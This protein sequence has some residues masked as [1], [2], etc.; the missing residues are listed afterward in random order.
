MEVA[1]P[2]CALVFDFDGTLSVGLYLERL[3]Q[4]AVA[5]KVP[6]FASMS[7]AE[8][9]LNFGG[10]ARLGALRAL[11]GELRASN[12]ALFVCSIGYKKAIVPHLERMDLL[13]FFG[14]ARV[15]GQ[16][17]EEL[18][19]RQFAKADFVRDLVALPLG[20]EPTRVL[21]ID[22]SPKHI[23]YARATGACDTLHVAGGHG[24]SDDDLDAIRQ[25]RSS[26]VGQHLE[27]AV[28]E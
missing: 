16:D 27:G 9:C 23:D 12:S 8:M 13:R 11:L 6:L 15:F 21:F 28:G 2:D 24:L 22:D 1:H 25:W 10:T 17:C 26:V 18:Q 4:W 7:E 20:L 5:D 14:E 19:E 3:Q